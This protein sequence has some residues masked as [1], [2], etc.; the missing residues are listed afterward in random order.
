LQKTYK[1]DVENLK[2]NKIEIAE[3]RDNVLQKL[4]GYLPFANQASL[5]KSKVGMVAEL[6][7]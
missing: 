2:V 5:L 3:S 1:I 6:N 4:M 7:F